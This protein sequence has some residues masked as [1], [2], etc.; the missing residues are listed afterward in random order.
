[1]NIW[2]PNA[3]E[4]Q[5]TN[6]F[7]AM[8][9]LGFENYKDFW[10]WS[11]DR[12]ESF[13][14]FVI[15][16]LEIPFFKKP[17]QILDLT[18]GVTQ[19]KW[20]NEAKLNIAEACFTQSPDA[21]AVIFQKEGGDIQFWTYQKL[22]KLVNQI[23]NS[24]Q[25]IGLQKGDV[26][27]IDMSMNVEAIAIYLAGIKAG[28]TVVTI[29]DSFTSQEI[30]V[31]IELTKPLLV[32]T[33]S[34]LF[35]NEKQLPLYQ[36]VVEANSPKIVL[37]NTLDSS[38]TLRK[39][40][41]FWADFLSENDIFFS[42]P[43][44]PDDIITVL[45]SSGTTAVPKAIP[46]TH[47]TPI[48]S[49]SDGYFHQDIQPG[50]VVA[51]PTNL[52]WMMGPWLVFATF[53]NKGTMAVFEGSP[54][55]K[56]FGKFVEESKV[57]MLGVVP[58]IVK[59]WKNTG[60][61]ETYHWNSIKCFSS[62]GEASHPDDYTYLMKLAGNKPII[63]YCGGTEIG[64]GYL[65]STLVQNNIP[66]TFST[67]ALGSDFVILDENHEKNS[68]GE[69]F[70]IPPTLGLSNS[71]LNKN[72]YEVYYQDIEPYKGQTLRRHGDQ[73]EELSTGYFK[74]QGRVD[75]AMNLGGIKV[76]SLEIETCV[77]SLEFI[78]ES[79]AISVAP[80][81]GGP[82]NLIIYFVPQYKIDYSTALSE[83]SQK[84]KNEIN[85]LFK[86]VDVV[87][88]DTLPRTSSGKVMRR[89]LRKWY[90]ER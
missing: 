85:P 58:G 87:S 37:L 73:I 62:T 6:I 11:V 16:T 79:A 80:K 66:S 61:M 4:L 63:E 86:V 26:I 72:H 29:A 13:W 50:D 21:T 2:Y 67:K 38:I 64:G 70:L 81:G 36:K 53:I 45:F 20:L 31:R 83:L 3:L 32:F 56:E 12:R 65:C 33:Q 49:A 47:I 46:W 82:E 1:M 41:V 24:F 8:K 22:E 7:Q 75:D 28:L 78:L 84:I 51:W 54:I 74:A 34:Y 68:I 48:K 5:K 40:D 89:T 14:E 55:G 9:K 18:H 39:N 88:I 15:N 69:V 60:C 23:A 30:A 10:Q 25:K 57:S 19:P 27:A 77:N 59:H 17:N 71:L 44:A 76:S 43:C 52:G 90:V 35:R 42:V